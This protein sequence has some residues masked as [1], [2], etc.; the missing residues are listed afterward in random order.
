MSDPD[1]LY[2]SQSAAIIER[3]ISAA[4]SCLS[5]GSGL[6]FRSS[7][8]GARSEALRLAQT[9]RERLDRLIQEL[10]GGP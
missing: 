6:V 2:L 9:A 1:F 4:A 3:D 8:R 5:V 10:G 7:R